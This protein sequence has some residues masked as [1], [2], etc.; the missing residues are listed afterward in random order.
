MGVVDWKSEPLGPAQAA[1]RVTDAFA[2]LQA[3]SGDPALGGYRILRPSAVA[4]PTVRGRGVSTFAVG[5]LLSVLLAAALGAAALAGPASCPCAPA[6]GETAGLA[7]FAYAKEAVLVPESSAPAILAAMLVEPAAAKDA[8]AMS[9]AAIATL[10]AVARR[11]SSLTIADGL[12]PKLETIAD[13]GP[14]PLR[15]A[16][17]SLSDDPPE[18]LPQVVPTPPLLDI[19]ATDAKPEHSEHK[20]QR[21]HYRR[22]R[23]F[24]ARHRAKADSASAG[25]A[26]TVPRAPRWAQQMYVTPWQSK[27]FSYSR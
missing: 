10:P 13:A 6:G 5:R 14:P 3:G 9:T 27:A 23:H 15:L 8:S 22:A 16:S 1:L 24:A 12:P 18:A 26:M 21:R 7:R 2:A 25:G 4:A 11:G 17:A 20:S 19:L